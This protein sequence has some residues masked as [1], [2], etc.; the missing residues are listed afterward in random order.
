[1]KSLYYRDDRTIK[2]NCHKRKFKPVFNS[3]NREIS[4]ERI[5]HIQRSGTIR[6]CSIKGENIIDGH[7]IGLVNLDG[8]LKMRYH[9]V[10][11][12]GELMIGV[13]I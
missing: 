2:I 1:M 3:D 5:F 4:S 8:Y 6:R 9:K 11:K 13:R 12:S 7:L 10:N